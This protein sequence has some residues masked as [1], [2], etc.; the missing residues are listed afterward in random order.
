MMARH[1]KKGRSKGGGHFV[2]LH[3]WMMNSAAWQSLS[4]A[5]RAIYIEV[6]RL[7]NGSNNGFLGLGVR[8]A[9][10]RTNV[11]KDTAAKCF[12]VLVARGF[13]EPA[14]QGQFNRNARRATEWRLT[15]H[16][17]D[18]THQLPSKAFMSWRPADLERR[19]KRGTAKSETGG[20]QQPA[21]VASVPRLR[22]ISGGLAVG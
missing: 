18:R 4:P 6:A 10:E 9:A 11:N 16:K 22:T 20:H 19:P 2:Q 8:A 1:N 14:Q 17:C 12:A 5:E 15:I 21:M 13:M 7:Y 3:D